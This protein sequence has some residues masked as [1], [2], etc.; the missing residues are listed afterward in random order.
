MRTNVLP[1]T[2]LALTIFGI[3]ASGLIGQGFVGQLKRLKSG[4]IWRATQGQPS[5][6]S[7]AFLT[8]NPMLSPEEVNARRHDPLIAKLLTHAVDRDRDGWTRSAL[9]NVARTGFFSSDRAIRDYLDRIWH[10]APVPAAGSR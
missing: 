8:T 6:L 1:A 3:G 10:V 5:P 2:G 9:H 4:G 7:G